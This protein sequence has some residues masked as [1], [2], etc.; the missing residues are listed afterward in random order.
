MKLVPHSIIVE[1]H[2]RKHIFSS[3]CDV[4]FQESEKQWQWI[5]SVKARIQILRGLKKERIILD[6]IAELWLHESEI[7]TKE[8][9]QH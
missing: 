2:Y 3:P 8:F 6:G 9:D 7:E 5:I 4:Q 1:L